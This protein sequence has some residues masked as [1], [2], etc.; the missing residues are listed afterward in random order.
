MNISSVT[1]GSVTAA[2]SGGTQGVAQPAS[3]TSAATGSSVSTQ[4]PSPEQVARA[5]KQV[6]DAFAKKGT[7]L[8][9]S[10]E[11][12][13]VSGIDIVQFR[14]SIT[15]EVVGQYPQKAIVAMAD[16]MAQSKGGAGQ[17]MNVRA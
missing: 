7:N 1:S 15:N 2:P 6:N 3:A 14:D 16:E 11:R 13:K 9:A 17:L 10:I 4:A 8:S 5:V 12:D